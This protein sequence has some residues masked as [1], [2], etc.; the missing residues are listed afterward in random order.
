MSNCPICQTPLLARMNNNYTE[1]NC[2]YDCPIVNINGIHHY[3]TVYDEFNQIALGYKG[4]RA[5][6]YGYNGY[7]IWTWNKTM[8]NRNN[9]IKSDNKS[10]SAKRIINIIDKLSAFV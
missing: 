5:L 4:F 10:I 7:K 3:Y 2:I 8:L 1:S 9:I 6:I